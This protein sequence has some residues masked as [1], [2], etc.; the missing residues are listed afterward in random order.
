VAAF[1]AAALAYGYGFTL[2]QS[3]LV[4]AFALCASA[5][6][7]CAGIAF[8]AAHPSFDWDNPNH[9]N[10]GLRMIVPFVVNLGMLAACTFLLYFFR[11]VFPAHAALE[12][13]FLACATLQAAIAVTAMRAARRDFAA[14]EV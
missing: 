6:A 11:A 5:S 7:V 10:R 2:A 1:G 12:V 9:I 13:G 8:D 4:V 3:A 14:L